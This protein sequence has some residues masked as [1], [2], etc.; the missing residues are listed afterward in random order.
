MSMI[1]AILLAAALTPNPLARVDNSS[2]ANSSQREAIVLRMLGRFWGNAVDVHGRRIEPDSDEDRKTVPVS[3]AAAMRALD[4]G[5]I[6]GLAE[7]CG[8]QWEPHYFALTRS[9]RSMKMA[10]KQIAFLS[11]LHGAAQGA[12]V[13]ARAGRSCN[14]SERELAAS[15][16]AESA[17]LGLPT[18][19]ALPWHPGN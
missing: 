15:L 7:W 18:D 2:P 3:R 10:D 13:H 16:M 5:N 11:V 9:A 4:A 17:K 14:S 19:A 12:L 6:S 8:L 1:S